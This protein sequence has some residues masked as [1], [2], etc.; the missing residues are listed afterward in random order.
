MGRT[1]L[2]PQRLSE[3]KKEYIGQIIIFCE[4]KTEK[5]YF[6]Y[7]AEII[8]K[9]KFT[10]IEVVLETAN[11]NA[12]T[13]LNYAKS[14]MDDEENNRKYKNYGKYLVFD[15]DAPPDIQAV[16]MAAKDYEL[17]ISNHLFETW[18]LMHFEDVEVKLTKKQI[19]DRLMRHLHGDYIK[20]HKGKTREIVQNGSIEKAIDNAKVLE[21]NY[22]IEGKSIFSN[23]KDMNPYTSVHKLVEQFMIEVSGDL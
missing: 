13:V 11:G 20:G 16:V 1:Q 22:A 2:S 6:D 10:D 21:Q 18:L 9:N 15:C 5:Y 7:F 12:Q 19:Y 3:T 17:L 8:K 4:G 14:F 23:I